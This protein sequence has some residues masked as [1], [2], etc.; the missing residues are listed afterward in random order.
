[1]AE[2]RILAAETV[3]EVDVNDSADLADVT[4]CICLED[5]NEEA[6]SASS[7]RSVASLPCGHMFHKGCV[8]KWLTEKSTTCPL[9]KQQLRARSESEP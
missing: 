5:L 1:M 2:M 9:C 4:C 6:D 7:G 3:H 8:T